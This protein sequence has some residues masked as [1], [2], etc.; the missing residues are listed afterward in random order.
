MYTS[1]DQGPAGQ[2]ECQAD[3]DRRFAGKVR[4]EDW[5]FEV[6]SDGS[7]RHALLVRLPVC[8]GTFEF[9]ERAEAVAGMSLGTPHQVVRQGSLEERELLA[10]GTGPLGEGAGDGQK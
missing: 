1:A 3:F 5:G 9:A 7:G 2:E 10:Y 4:D 8:R 6:P